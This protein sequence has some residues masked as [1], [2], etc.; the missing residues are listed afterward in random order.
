VPAERLASDAAAVQRLTEEG[1]VT[2]AGGWLLLLPYRLR[3]WPIP[4]I[5]VRG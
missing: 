5:A 1:I 4:C 2:G 3:A